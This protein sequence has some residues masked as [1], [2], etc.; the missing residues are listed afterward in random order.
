MLLAPLKGG[1]GEEPPGADFVVE[2]ISGGFGEARPDL[3]HTPGR[4]A[5]AMEDPGIPFGKRVPTSGPASV[6]AAMGAVP[7]PALVLKGPLGSRSESKSRTQK[8]EVTGRA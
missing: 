6:S 8:R 5:G 1:G 3:A 7:H 4:G 2:A